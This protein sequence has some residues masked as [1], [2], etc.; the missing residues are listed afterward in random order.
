[1]STKSGEF[2]VGPVYLYILW[3]NLGRLT[4]FDMNM[5]YVPFVVW[6]VAAAWIF[7]SLTGFGSTFF[8]FSLVALLGGV[9]LVRFFLV[10]IAPRIGARRAAIGCSLVWLAGCVAVA[11][12]SPPIVD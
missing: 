12:L 10:R 1:M 5:I 8:Q 11:W 2:Q 3:T 4:L 9:Y 6:F 7:E